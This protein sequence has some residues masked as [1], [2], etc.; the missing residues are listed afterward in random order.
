VGRGGGGRPVSFARA[1]DLELG[2]SW[3]ATE[4][5]EAAGLSAIKLGGRI[6]QLIRDREKGLIGSRRGRG[7]GRRNV[8]RESRESAWVLS[9]DRPQDRSILICPD[10][11]CPPPV[12]SF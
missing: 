9:R 10:L 11:P 1:E 4:Y 3:S 5:V 12:I 2:A 7:R 6:R 8:E